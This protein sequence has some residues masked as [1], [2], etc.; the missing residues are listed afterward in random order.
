MN[1]ILHGIETPNIVRTNS[2]TE[3]L[4]DIQEKDRF[5]IILANPPFGGLDAVLCFLQL[6]A[7]NMVR[8]CECSPRT[9]LC[10]VLLPAA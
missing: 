1:M 4:N 6:V 10:S 3:D 9:Y 5:D 7:D 2:L 8:A